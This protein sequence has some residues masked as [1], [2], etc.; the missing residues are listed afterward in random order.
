MWKEFG[1]RLLTE[2]KIIKLNWIKVILFS[3]INFYFVFI[4]LKN[5]GLYYFVD[6]KNVIFKDIGHYYLPEYFKVNI[7]DI[8]QSIAWIMSL[9]P[10]IYIPIFPV[11]HKNKI[12]SIKTFLICSY[13]CNLIYLIRFVSVLIS[14]FPD[15]SHFCRFNTIPRPSST[16]GKYIFNRPKFISSIIFKMKNLI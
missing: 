8:P 11:F 6:R 9:S 10:L 12:Y 5:I 1:R 7:H 2:L 13:F 16:Y 4:I 3:L 15:P 14:Q